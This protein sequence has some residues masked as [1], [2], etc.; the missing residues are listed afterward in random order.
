MINGIH[1]GPLDPDPEGQNRQD[2]QDCLEVCV[3]V[4]YP[5]LH[6]PLQLVEP[7]GSHH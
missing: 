2:P 3:Q 7:K 6:Q 4:R 5:R 1:L